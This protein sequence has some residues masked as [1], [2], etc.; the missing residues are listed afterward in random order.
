MQTF[1]IIV[2]LFA[3]I[4]CIAAQVVVTYLQSRPQTQ[5]V[6]TPADAEPAP[7]PAAKTAAAKTA[8]AKAATAKAEADAAE[9]A[10][11]AA[12]ESAS[13]S[14]M[15]RVKRHTS[16]ALGSQTAADTKLGMLGLVLLLIAVAL[17]INISVTF[18]L[19]T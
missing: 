17:V 3:G 18:T 16:A 19:A 5:S 1:V 15:D 9:A 4:L 12:T 2:L 13:A 8:A 11:A 7:A 14:T 6:P 10:N